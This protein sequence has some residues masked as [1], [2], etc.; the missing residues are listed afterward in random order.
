[1]DGSRWEA[2][3]VL[4][5]TSGES[6]T[7]PKNAGI[8]RRNYSL[9]C[10]VIMS[11]LSCEELNERM[12]DVVERIG[13]MGRQAKVLPLVRV[14]DAL[15]YPSFLSQWRKSLAVKVLLWNTGEA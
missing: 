9:E 8:R 14:Y 6:P 4:D 1:M 13:A 12:S 10:V 2:T 15:T 7:H 11:T 3:R 5:M